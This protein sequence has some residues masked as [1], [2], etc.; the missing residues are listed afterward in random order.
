VIWG[1]TRFHVAV[2]PTRPLTAVAQIADIEQAVLASGTIEPYSLV[3]VGAQA[4]GQIKSLKVKPG[5][6]V[7]A[8]DLIAEIDSVTEENA[9]KNARAAVGI[10]HAQRRAQVAFLKQF[11]LAFERQRIMLDQEATSRADYESAEATLEN[12]RAQ[13]AMVDAQILQGQTALDTAIATLGYTKIRAPLSGTVVA[14]IAKEGQ[15]VNANQNTPTIVKLAQLDTVTVN[16]EISEADVSKV[17][18]GQRVYFTVLGNPQKRFYG[19]LRTIEPAPRSIEAESSLSA[20]SSAAGTSNEAV[21]YTGQLDVP[22]PDGELRVSMT[23]EVHIILTEAK[24]ALII[25][26][27]ALCERGDGGYTVMVLG[28][29]GKSTAR[30]IHIGINNSVTVQ[31]VA[32]LTAG[33]LVV[34]SR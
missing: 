4:S 6:R 30:R 2:I 27:A 24:D 13:I 21:Y 15:T 7:H 11:E 26:S 32:G 28:V 9:L 25:P 8:G 34:L 14:V 17:K 16:V 10:L 29:D 3:S 20:A 18:A 23:A 22:N 1:T 5:A 19:K 31:V 12:M 33:E